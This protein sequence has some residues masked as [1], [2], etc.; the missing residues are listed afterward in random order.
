MGRD[1]HVLSYG[2][3]YRTS[4]SQVRGHPGGPK[5]P[6][7]IVEHTFPDGLHVPVAAD[8]PG[9][10]RTLT[11]RNAEQDS[12]WLP[13]HVNDNKRRTFCVYESPSP[14]EIRKA[15]G[16]TTCRPAGLHG[17]RCSTLLLHMRY[18]PCADHQRP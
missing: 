4:C 5:T 3:S 10:S 13:S 11:Q 8:G 7:Y 14:K 9:L 2:R 17:D 12:T 1:P 6:R 15:V 18:L 16:R